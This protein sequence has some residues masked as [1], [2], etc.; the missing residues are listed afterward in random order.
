MKPVLRPKHQ[1]P[2]SV[3]NKFGKELDRLEK[4]AVIQSTDYSTWV[5]SIAVVRKA[6]GTIRLC[7]DFSTRLDGDLSKLEFYLKYTSSVVN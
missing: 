4:L 6:N 1:V 2:Y 5:T 3:I 7:A